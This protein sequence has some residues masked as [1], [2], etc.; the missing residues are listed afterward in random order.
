MWVGDCCVGYICKEFS[1]FR[2]RFRLDYNGWQVQGNWL[3]WEYAIVDSAARTV[4]TVSKEIWHWTDT[5]TI[6]VYD[7][8][9]AVY[10]LMLVLAIDVEKCSRQD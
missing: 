7:A 3:E 10:A 1:F 6:D 2:P 4:A 5:Y 9:D 8:Q